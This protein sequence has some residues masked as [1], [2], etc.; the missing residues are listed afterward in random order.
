MPSTHGQR[1]PVDIDEDGFRQDNDMDDS[2]PAEESIDDEAY[3]QP[4]RK[5]E[6]MEV[7]GLAI[8]IQKHAEKE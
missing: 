6:E 3:E 5:T 2:K 8:A 7:E 4:F 1:I